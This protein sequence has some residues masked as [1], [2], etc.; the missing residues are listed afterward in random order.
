M[1]IALSLL[2]L[3]VLVS[4]AACTNDPAP[5]QTSL[6]LVT[7][8]AGARMDTLPNITFAAGETAGGPVLTVWPD[9]LKQTIHGIGTSFTESSAFV[10]AHLEPARRREVMEM[11]YGEDGANFTLTRTHIASCDFTVEGRYAYVEPDDAELA[12]FTIAPDRAGFDPAKYPGIQDP[13]YD[14]LPMI[15]EAIAIKRAQGDPPPR[16]IAS[17]WTAP[18]WMKD[19][20]TWF[21]PGSEENGWQGT[22]GSLKPGFEAAYA[23]Y[24]VKYLDAYEAEGVPVWGLTP[25]NEPHG[26]GGHWESMNFTAA[27]QGA[28]IKDHLGPRL[29]AGGHDDKKLLIFDQNRD[30]VDEWADVIFGD[31]AAAPWVDGMAVHWYAST[32]KVFED[33]FERV[34]AKY[35]AME[36]IHT[37]GCIDNLG[38]PAPG[39]VTDPRGFQE[40]PNW[41]LNDAWW[42]NKHATDWAYSV[43]WEGFDAADHPMYTPVH[44]YARNIIVSLDHWLAGWVDWNI[45]LDR[46]GGPNHVSNFCGA[47]IMIDTATGEIH[48]TPVFWVLAQFSRTI[49]PGDRAVWTRLERGGLGDDDLHACATIDDEG[50]VSVQLLNTTKEEIGFDLKVGGRVAAVTVPANAVQTVRF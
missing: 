17:A 18:P 13:E 5:P 27:S 48:D 24:L 44:R 39:G 41:F 32:F 47:P 40:E 37:E 22:G 4:F 19:I 7:S 28:F 23:G 33:A 15:E 6:I 50:V 38:G 36:I 46:H 11:I 14:L 42:W 30:G 34:H 20:E 9:S 10:L 8:E 21:I 45:V 49:R 26:N 25:V 29:K 35:P 1:R 3:A 31:P 12:T 2:S 16:I 43:T